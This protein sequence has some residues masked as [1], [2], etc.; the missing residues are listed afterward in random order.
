ML[1]DLLRRRP[2]LRLVLMSATLNAGLFA[3]YFRIDKEVPTVRVPGRAH[4]VTPLY[5]EDVLEL[6]GHKVRPGADWARKPPRD[7]GLAA[8]EDVRTVLDVDLPEVCRT[9]VPG[10]W[11]GARRPSHLF[12]IPDR[13]PC[14][15]TPRS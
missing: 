7:K 9:L 6:T 2:T 4:T 14:G 15:F 1:R 11:V 3:G 8:G 10:S 12:L 5:L 13:V